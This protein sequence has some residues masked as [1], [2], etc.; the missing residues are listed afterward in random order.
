MHA[1]L[2]FWK[3]NSRQFFAVTEEDLLVPAKKKNRNADSRTDTTDMTTFGSGC[4]CNCEEALENI[5]K[6]LVELQGKMS[7]VFELTKSSKVP[8]GLW[9]LVGEAFKCKICR[10]MIR[11]P[12][13]VTKCCKAMLGCDECV[14]SCYCM[15]AI[16]WLKTAQ[17]AT[18]RGDMGRVRAAY[19]DLMSFSQLL[20][21]LSKTE[22]LLCPSVFHQLIQ[23]V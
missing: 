17:A 13:V 8:L 18:Q 14:K 19:M 6:E 23:T 1:G 2:K 20:K 4:S 12:V 21:R 5:T 11:P 22:Q 16:P 7:R 3:V 9:E 15:L 10:D